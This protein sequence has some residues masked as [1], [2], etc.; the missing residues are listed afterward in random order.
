MNKT[1]TIIERNKRNITDILENPIETDM[2]FRE[3]QRD[4]IGK[5]SSNPTWGYAYSCRNGKLKYK[6]IGLYKEFDYDAPNASYSE[7]VWSIIGKN[8]LDGTRVPDISVVEE[9]KGQ[10]GIISYRLLD[11]DKEDLIH[12][13]DIL[14]NKFERS[15]I[16]EKRNIIYIE[17]LLECFK[18]QIGDEENYNSVRKSVIHT[19]LLDAVTNNADRHGNNWGLIR[20][21]KTNRYEFAD[22]DH[23][24]SFV[25][26]FEDKKHFTVNGWVSSYTSVKPTNQETRMG[27]CGNEIIE[28]I[29]K[30]YREDFKDFSI[31]FNNRLP[32]I[33]EEIKDEKLDINIDRL[34]RRL[35]DKKRFL[36]QL[37]R[38]EGEIEYE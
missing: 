10:P 15:E 7:K 12:V 4:T 38:E 5:S 33:I 31:K 26:M 25:D 13:K 16:K 35:N 2:L 28:Y 32:N 36:K 27:S 1:I 34:E 14:F 11:N 23:S 17:D 29:A 19:L 30:N 9:R 21:K 3:I 8:I 6:G 18:L 24:S 20:N 37:S 22:F